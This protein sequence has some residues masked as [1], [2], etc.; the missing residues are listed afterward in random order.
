MQIRYAYS[1]IQLSEVKIKQNS[2]HNENDLKI[3]AYFVKE[4]QKNLTIVKLSFT[5]TWGNLHV[6]LISV[7]TLNT[8]TTKNDSILPHTF[9]NF[10][11]HID[12]K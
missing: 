7:L 11:L 2:L 4:K 5:Q 9:L 8:S 1:K 3:L 6:H 10:C 12:G